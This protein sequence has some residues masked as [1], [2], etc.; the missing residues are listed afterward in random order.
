ML[1]GGTWSMRGEMAALLMGL[2][3][4]YFLI[5]SNVFVS[6][7]WKQ[8]SSGQLQRSTSTHHRSVILGS[9]NES[10]HI[11]RKGEVW[12]LLLEVAALDQAFTGR[13]LIGK[14]PTTF[15]ADKDLLVERAPQSP[16][17]L[18]DTNI[19]RYSHH[20]AVAALRVKDLNAAR[21]IAPWVSE[22][23]K[24]LISR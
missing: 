21:L 10:H 7:N 3:L 16:R 24:S 12:D 9:N 4:T 6:Y 2:S 19:H 17:G 1:Q 11:L 13:C 20:R 14:D 23:C 22:D 8:T 18:G 15:V 5:G